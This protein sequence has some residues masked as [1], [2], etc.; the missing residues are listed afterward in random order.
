MNAIATQ[1]KAIMQRHRMRGVVEPDLSLDAKRAIENIGP[2]GG[3]L[4]NVVG[5][6][7]A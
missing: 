5:G 4:T 1:Q 7:A 6:E 2:P 3:T